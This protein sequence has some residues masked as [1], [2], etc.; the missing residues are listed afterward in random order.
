[1][2]KVQ[3]T[4]KSF[5]DKFKH[6][7]FLSDDKFKMYGYIPNGESEPKMLTIPLSFSPKGRTFTKLKV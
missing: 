2:I 6:V 7:Y 1:M 5:E 4:T 3:E